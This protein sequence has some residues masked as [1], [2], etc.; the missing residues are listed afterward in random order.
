[1]YNINI[2]IIINKSNFVLIIDFIGF[3]LLL[4]KKKKKLYFYGIY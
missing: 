2:E 4:L 3:E 1:M